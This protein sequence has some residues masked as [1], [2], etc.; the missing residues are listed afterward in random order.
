MTQYIRFDWV[1]KYMLRD[2]ANYV[3]LEGF[4]SELLQQDITIQEILE[5]ES[6]TLKYQEK[7]NRVDALVKNQHGEL[8]IIELQYESELDYFQRI[9]FGVARLINQYIKKGEPY[10][11]VK[12][13]IS[14]SLVYFDLGEGTD[15]VYV[16]TTE[17]RGLHQQ[18]LLKLSEKQQEA[19]HCETIAQ[20]YPTYYL[21]KIN[22]FADVI[23]D[24][25]D[26][27]LYFLKH[28]RI[29]E[30]FKAKGL[31]EAKE[32]LDVVKLPTRERKKYD[33]FLEYLHFE[34]S[35]VESKYLEGKLDGHA[36]GHT[37][38]H[39]E[40]HAEAKQEMARTMKQEGL[41]LAMIAKITGLTEAEI[42]SL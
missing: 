9:L 12:K 30:E 16:G 39:T 25:L 37:E 18:D 14:V 7:L 15:Y 24:R 20:L 33:R 17:F 11:Q 41:P 21:L 2:K 1:I 13:V 26:E 3:V 34:A 19:Y 40:G 29:N 23:E 27:W 8:I 28:E 5:S 35:I 6:N 32:K 10:S 38:G 42:M 36:E 22:K 31:A 4:L